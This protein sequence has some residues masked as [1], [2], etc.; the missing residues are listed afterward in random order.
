MGN[1]SREA[2]RWLLVLAIHHVD[3]GLLV[4]GAMKSVRNEKIRAQDM[5]TA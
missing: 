2:K 5:R 3:G 4:M 1:D